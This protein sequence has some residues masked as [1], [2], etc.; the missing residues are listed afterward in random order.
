MV[1]PYDLRWSNYVMVSFPSSTCPLLSWS[2]GGVCGVG[3]LLLFFGGLCMCVVFLYEFWTSF[4]G[5]EGGG[6]P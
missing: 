1:V 4:V 3:V 6:M 2:D 5:G